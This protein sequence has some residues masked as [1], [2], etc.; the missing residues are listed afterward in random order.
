MLDEAKACHQRA[1]DGARQG[2][3]DSAA[4]HEG[5][6][7]AKAFQGSSNTD[8]A[9]ALVEARRIPRPSDDKAWDATRK[10]IDT[11]RKKLSKKDRA[12]AR[13]RP[14]R[15]SVTAGQIADARGAAGMSIERSSVEN[16]TRVRWCRYCCVIP[17]ASGEEFCTAHMRQ[18]SHDERQDILDEKSETLIEREDFSPERLE[19]ERAKALQ[20]IAQAAD[21]RRREAA[22]GKAGR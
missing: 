20:R 13:A 17:A 2:G 12:W 3:R 1:E 18:L 14:E 4:W 9:R 7:A 8:I 21:E 6:C 16:D 22:S 11:A 10:R 15:G 19:R 5:D